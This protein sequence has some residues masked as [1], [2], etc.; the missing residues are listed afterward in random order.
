MITILI[1]AI[2]G[3]VNALYLHYQYRQYLN[4]GKKMFC[5]I[6]GGCG[7]IVSSKYGQTLGVKNELMGM[8]YYILLIIYSVGNLLLPQI[9]S[10][11]LIWVKLAAILATIFSLYLLFIQAF[12]LRKF[13]SWCVIATT[14]NLL[15]FAFLNL[16]S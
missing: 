4:S 16:F 14:I 10:T 7:E 2:L 1:L 12:M 13:C 9:E 11:F 8:I 6:G 15:I 3:L 5:L